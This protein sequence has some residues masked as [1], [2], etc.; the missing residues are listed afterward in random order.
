MLTKIL[1]FVLGSVGA[2]IIALA[3]MPVITRLYSPEE[4]GFFSMYLSI[5]V[6]ITSISI[7]KLDQA[8]YKVKDKKQTSGLV[9]LICISLVTVCVLTAIITFSASYYTEQ[10][11]LL[12]ITLGVISLSLFEFC[13]AL[14][15]SLNLVRKIRNFRVIQAMVIGLSQISLYWLLN[16]YRGLIIG[17]IVGY[18]IFII[19][20]LNASKLELSISFKYENLKNTFVSYKDFIKYQA[21]ASLLNSLSQNLIIVIIA[22]GYGEQLAGLY[23]LTYKILTLPNSI[24]GNAVRQIFY[25]NA[26]DIKSNAKLLYKT[27]LKTTCC[28]GLVSI[29]GFGVGFFTYDFLF[30]TFFGEAWADSAMIAKILTPWFMIML[31]NPPSIALFNVLDKQKNYFVFELINSIFRISILVMSPLMGYE[32]TTLLIIYVSQAV[33]MNLIVITLSERSLSKLCK[34]DCINMT[35]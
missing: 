28:L 7:L 6:I 15:I 31:I 17:H 35:C 2:Q 4:Y 27:Y 26:E 30:V 14:G 8:I 10:S 33:I 11:N 12:W 16:D 3:L 24:I 25:K 32:F 13:I 34:K 18:G 20:M 22:W 9:G 29:V 23:G 5:S 19:L 21:P 1:N